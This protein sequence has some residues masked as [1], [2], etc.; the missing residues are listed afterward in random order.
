M[1]STLGG[2]SKTP[3]AFSKSEGLD[4]GIPLW[5]GKGSFLI[6]VVGPNIKG[7]AFSARQNLCCRLI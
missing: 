1:K 2:L 6:I 4:G 3:T 5:E 7:I